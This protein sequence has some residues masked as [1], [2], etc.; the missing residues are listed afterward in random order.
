M[1]PARISKRRILLDCHRL[2]F[3]YHAEARGFYAATVVVD[4][5]NGAVVDG[6]RSSV[7]AVHPLCLPI[8]PGR[9]R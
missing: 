9:G 8:K 2:H 7:A 6:V 3:W 1:S 5:T 4:I